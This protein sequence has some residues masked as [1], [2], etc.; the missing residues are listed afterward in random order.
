MALPLLRG[1]SCPKN[2]RSRWT[3]FEGQDHAYPEQA[4]SINSSG[5]NDYAFN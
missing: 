4:H 1:S 5:A 3:S 2:L